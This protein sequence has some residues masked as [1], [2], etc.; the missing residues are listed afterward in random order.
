MN[1]FHI[2]KHEL[3]SQTYTRHLFKH[4]QYTYYIPLRNLKVPV[5]AD[6]VVLTDFESALSAEVTVEEHWILRIAQ[7][8]DQPLVFQEKVVRALALGCH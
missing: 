3:C 1:D 7:R 8:A 2:Q 4:R 6:G 5:G